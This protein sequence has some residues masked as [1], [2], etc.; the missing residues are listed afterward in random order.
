MEYNVSGKNSTFGSCSNNLASQNGEQ[1]VE[2]REET[3][4]RHS[5]LQHNNFDMGDNRVF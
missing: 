5:A 2:F 3:T 1:I 4:M